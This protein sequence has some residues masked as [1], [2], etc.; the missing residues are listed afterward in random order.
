MEDI[1]SLLC[2]AVT[3]TAEGEAARLHPECVGTYTPSGHYSSG[4]PVLSTPRTGQHLYVP[5]C[6]LC[7]CVQG[8]I[9]K[10]PGLGLQS[11]CAPSLCP[12]DPRAGSSHWRGETRRSWG[13]AGSGDWRD[14]PGVLVTCNTH[15]FHV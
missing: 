3:I 15:M 4:R 7:W 12:A 11:G 5:D 8:D 10:V 14:C 13:M 9:R 1:S 2:S 6:S